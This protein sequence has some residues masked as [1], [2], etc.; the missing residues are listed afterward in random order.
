MRASNHIC[1][2]AVAG[3]LALV[4]PVCLAVDAP[5]N[6]AAVPVH[7]GKGFL[8]HV[9][10]MRTEDGALREWAR[11]QK[12]KPHLFKDLSPT[13]V[14]TKVGDK[15]VFYRLYAGTLPDDASAKALCA[16]LQPDGGYCA[17]VKN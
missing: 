12:T 1:S 6:P 15:G 8:V 11:L 2:L 9:A 7:A 4:A 14:T 5:A 13:L 3:A 10:S 16:A 17:I